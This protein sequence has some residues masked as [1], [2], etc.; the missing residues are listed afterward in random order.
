MEGGD[1][2][3]CL[4]K[5]YKPDNVEESDLIAGGVKDGICG[6]IPFAQLSYGKLGESTLKQF[7]SNIAA[8]SI[9]AGPDTFSQHAA[10]ALKKF[11]LTV[12]CC[13]MNEA[14]SE[15]HAT[16]EKAF[17]LDGYNIHVPGILDGRCIALSLHAL[18]ELEDGTPVL[19]PKEKNTVGEEIAR[20]I[21]WKT[22]GMKA[23]S[24]WKSAEAREYFKDLMENVLDIMPMMN[25]EYR[26][27]ARENNEHPKALNQMEFLSSYVEKTGELCGA[28]RTWLDSNMHHT[29]KIAYGRGG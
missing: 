5:G 7:V 21:L 14:K 20:K 15:Y 4:E 6:G 22:N 23:I 13:G 24:D 18:T 19:F 12:F 29:L 1:A 27:L 9:V 28:F 10:D 3:I 11:S 2:A 25:E 8:S 17:C 16:G 26:I